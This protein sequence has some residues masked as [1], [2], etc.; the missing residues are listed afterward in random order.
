MCLEEGGNLV[1]EGNQ[2]QPRLKGGS[3]LLIWREGLGFHTHI[4]M[5]LT[6]HLITHCLNEMFISCDS[7][8]APPCL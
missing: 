3:H 2:R 7:S 5:G 4:D 6:P 8:P 1:G